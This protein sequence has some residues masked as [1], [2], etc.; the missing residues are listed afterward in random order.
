MTEGEFKAIP[1]AGFELSSKIYELLNLAQSLKYIKKGVNE[2]VKSITKG[3]TEIVIL[4]ADTKPLELVSPVVR[5]CEENSIPYCFV[6]SQACLGWA[7]GI[8]R[9]VIC[10]SLIQSENTNIQN[11]VNVLKEKVEMLFY[12]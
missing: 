1:D 12:D 9:P 3:T 7:C 10:C 8:S 11:Q 6:D 5:H 2:T 4:A